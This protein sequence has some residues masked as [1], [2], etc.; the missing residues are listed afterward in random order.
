LGPVVVVCMGVVLSWFTSAGPRRTG[1]PRVTTGGGRPPVAP[2]AVVMPHY[3]GGAG[4]HSADAAGP[5]PDAGRRLVLD[6][7]TAHVGAGLDHAQR[8]RP[9][10]GHHE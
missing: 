2:A 10:A 7:V 8:G 3:R 9:A 5:G 4:S 6:A 1:M